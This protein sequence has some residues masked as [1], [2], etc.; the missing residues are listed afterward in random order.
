MFN[1]F[2][3]LCQFYISKLTLYIYCHEIIVVYLLYLIYMFSYVYVQRFEQAL[4]MKRAL[5][6]FGILIKLITGK[7]HLSHINVTIS[8]ALFITK[9]VRNV[10]PALTIQILYFALIHPFLF[11]GFT[12][13]GNASQSHLRT[14]FNLQ[15]QANR[16][17]IEV[18]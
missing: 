13:W 3:F 18:S 4:S 11:Y 5:Y 10:L 17:I 2:F 6:K 16:I 1:L 12:L 8:R 15:T 14:I 9:H 7:H